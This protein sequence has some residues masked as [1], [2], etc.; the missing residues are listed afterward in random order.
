M[1]K[2]AFSFLILAALIFPILSGCAKDDAPKANEETVSIAGSA[3]EKI[4]EKRVF[5]FSV[6]SSLSA[7]YTERKYEMAKKIAP[8]L[9]DLEAKE[10][11]ALALI[12]LYEDN[13]KTFRSYDLVRFYRELKTAA[14]QAGTTGT[15]PSEFLLRGGRLFNVRETLEALLALDVY[16]DRLDEEQIARMMRDFEEFAA[17][18]Q[19]AKEEVYPGEVSSG[20]KFAIFR[21]YL[22]SGPAKF[23]VE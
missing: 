16:Y 15:A 7:M 21:R 3:V 12:G 17:L 18:E 22:K 11:S 4:Q 5:D 13:L 8:E 23:P 2:I 19:A 14:E 10:D 1:K 20:T 9:N 6:D